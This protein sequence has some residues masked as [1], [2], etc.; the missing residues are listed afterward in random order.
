MT[1][2]KK[3]RRLSPVKLITYSVLLITAIVFILYVF[4]DR[5]TP[6][7]EQAR[8]DG[9]VVPISPRVSGYLTEIRVRLHT[10][11]KVGDT[12]F[13]LDRRPF[14]LAVQSAE[15][16]VDNTAQMVSARTASVKSA[17]GRLGVARAQLDRAQR[18][19]DRVQVIIND[20]PGALSQS[21]KDQAETSLTQAVE[22][23]ASAEADLERSQQQLGVSGEENP[24]F[25]A[26]LTS[27]ENAQL[28][29]AFSTVIATA[30]GVIESFNLD[31]GYYAQAGQPLATLISRNDI[32]IQANLKEN[33]LSHLKPGD[34]VEF[35]LDVHPGSVY[36]GTVRSIGFGVSTTTKNK[37]EL[38]SIKGASGWLR[39]P[40]R[41]PVIISV[42]DSI[43]PELIRVGGQVD[44]V[45]YT[46]ESRFLNMLAR[47]RIRVNSWLSYLR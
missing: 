15:A 16:H 17:A 34:R 14:E 46:G 10:T 47:W 38:P 9:I 3:K 2:S 8:I 6:Y 42:D 43:S 1:E 44:I 35:T 4:A 39:D 5:Y 13:Q 28:N 19:W 23:V 33:N 41:F 40:Q 29:L 31:L 37:G 25:R 7:T 30:P 45:A 20:N 21:D 32:W 22:Q 12:L 24:Q 11:V 36:T 26:A 27:L 18:N